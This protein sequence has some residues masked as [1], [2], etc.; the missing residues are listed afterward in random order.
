VVIH[1]LGMRYDGLSTTKHPMHGALHSQQGYFQV[2]RTLG[3]VHQAHQQYLLRLWRNH[4]HLQYAQANY[5]RQLQA[6][7]GLHPIALRNP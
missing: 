1:D 7:H 3:T 5:M 6:Q 2:L 4:P